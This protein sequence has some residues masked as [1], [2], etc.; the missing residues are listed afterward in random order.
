MALVTQLISNIY[1]TEIVNVAF[2][3]KLIIG[4]LDSRE[5]LH[6]LLHKL[7]IIIPAYNSRHPLILKTKSM[8]QL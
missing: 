4:Q 1:R 7:S 6:K 8:P 5:L 3:F 2:I